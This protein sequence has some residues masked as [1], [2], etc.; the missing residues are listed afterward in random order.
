MFLR[1]CLLHPRRIY[2]YIYI[3]SFI[4]IFTYIHNDKYILQKY[5]TNFSQKFR[6][7]TSKDKQQDK[8]RKRRF[9]LEPE[10]KH[11]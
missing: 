7:K 4:E 8:K 10:E 11:T 1:K 3:S 5:D 2:V 6:W 9:S